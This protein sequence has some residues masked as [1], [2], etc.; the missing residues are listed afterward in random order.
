MNL[1]EVQLRLEESAATRRVKRVT[2]TWQR[3]L[4]GG[5][6]SS[7][8][9]ELLRDTY[10][11]FLPQ[12]TEILESRKS[13]FTGKEKFY[14][15]YNDYTARRISIIEK[16]GKKYA[17]KVTTATPELVAFTAAQ[18]IIEESVAQ[19]N[20]FWLSVLNFSK[21]IVFQLGGS[22]SKLNEIEEK[23]VTKACLE[24][25]SMVCLTSQ[26]YITD[27][28]IS[29]KRGGTWHFLAKRVRLTEER[30]KIVYGK[31]DFLKKEFPQHDPMVVPPID[32]L[33]L[34]S[35][36]GGYVSNE[37][38]LL[39]SPIKIKVDGKSVIHPSILECT[40]QTNKFAFGVFNRMQKVPYAI[41]IEMLEMIPAIYNYINNTDDSPENEKFNTGNEL[42][43]V[44]L[45][46]AKD[47]SIYENIYF[48]LFLDPRFRMYTWASNGL[49]YQGND[50][51]KSV[52]RYGPSYSKALNAEGIAALKF[53]L[54]EYLG[55]AKKVG[56]S[57]MDVIEEALPELLRKYSIKDFSFIKGNSD[58][59]GMIVIIKEL[60]NASV[61]PDYICGKVLHRDACTSGI[62][63]MGLFTGCLDTMKSTNIFEPEGDDLEDLYLKTASDVRTYVEILLKRPKEIP[64]EDAP[65]ETKKA[66]SL[67]R[68]AQ[69]IKEEEGFL[70]DRKIV[71]RSSMTFLNYAAAKTSCSRDIVEQTKTRYPELME[72]LLE[73]QLKVEEKICSDQGLVKNCFPLLS[74][75]CDIIWH[76]LQV[77]NPTAL[78][79]QKWLKRMIRNACKESDCFAYKNPLTDLPVV[80]RKKA[81]TS[82][83]V[84]TGLM[85]D[86]PD[87]D[88][89]LTVGKNSRK[90]MSSRLRTKFKLRTENMDLNK[91]VTSALPGTIHGADAS[92]MMLIEER[93]GYVTGIHDSAGC[94]PNDTP[95]LIEAIGVAL[96]KSYRSRYFESMAEQ[97]GYDLDK[98]PVPRVDTY[99]YDSR[100]LNTVY[101]FS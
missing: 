26:M 79:S 22:F 76:A 20:V 80:L 48:P 74:A 65:K 95:A 1:F 100:I 92:V 97:T 54:G 61:N 27:A 29:Y 33:D 87:Y 23:E 49:T 37:S 91:T 53:S 50:L 28:P 52:V 34:V 46:A 13:K 16:Y 64:A 78:N 63:L 59:F 36:R 45:D 2:D 38:P 89:S 47:F 17:E 3:D 35:T 14:S 6:G 96:D 39:K 41:D 85:V 60:Y 83:E 30:L 73:R 44:I 84:C 43:K 5:A 58:P 88:S 11:E 12:I 70:F 71:K 75:L 82:T 42:N 10:F 90:K 18:A 62:Q 40:A 25:L 93:L 9:S 55:V 66:Y 31:L 15:L 101:A 51:A 8:Y 21:K 86:N 69:L 57:R 72:L 94:H 56:D 99:E 4:K 68:C 32:H 98:D 24:L 7:I 81:F 19:S 67:Y 77:G